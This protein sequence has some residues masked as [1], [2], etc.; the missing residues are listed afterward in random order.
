MYTLNSLLFLCVI[1]AIVLF[2]FESL[3]VR[4]YVTLKCRQL[5]E[6]SGLQL[7][8]QTVALVSISVARSISRR[9]QIRRIYRFEVS[10]NGADRLN[11]Y[12]T[13]LGTGIEAIQVDDHDGMTT[14][15]PVIP[16]QIQPH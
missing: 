8:D 6:T 5:C 13:M 14:I 16:G 3:R 9:L 11:G 12:I 7:L 15:Y 1:A 2:W 4:E 10:N